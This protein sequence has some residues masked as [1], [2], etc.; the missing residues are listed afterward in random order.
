MDVSR[1]SPTQEQQYLLELTTVLLFV[2]FAVLCTQGIIRQKWCPLIYDRDKTHFVFP[3]SV[4]CAVI[5][6]EHWFYTWCFSNSTIP[7]ALKKLELSDYG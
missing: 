2:I 7:W 1:K 6:Q 4:T 3:L 5:C